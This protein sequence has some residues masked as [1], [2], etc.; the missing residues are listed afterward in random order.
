MLQRLL[1][2]SLLIVV[3]PMEAREATEEG[4]TRLIA[5]ALRG[6]HR[7]PAFVERDRYRHPAETLRFFGWQPP[8]TVVEIWPSAGWYTEILAPIT[9]PR[10]VY[11]AA[12]FAMTAD[13]TPE[14]RKGVHKEFMEKLEKRPKVYD[15]TV[16]TG[17]SVP[18]R[19]TIAPP[20]SAD[21]VLTF[22]NVHNWMKG[23]YA[24]TMFRI[25]ARALKPGG[26]LGVVE[27]RARPGTTLE[28]M[29]ESGYVT[30][31]HVIKLA[32]RAGF[33]LEEKSEI[34]AN[35]ADTRDHP[36]GVWTLPPSLRHCRPIDAGPERE[37]CLE[38][39]RAIGESDRMT[40]RFRKAGHPQEDGR[41]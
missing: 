2:F 3:M 35:P 18:E 41:G 6:D 21:M 34:N 38:K 28:E 27:H 25:M 40:L 13:R 36:A 14:W 17:L 19:T 4:R 1:I 9:R 23:D 8:M 39:Y 20:G 30:E 22:R 32:G 10:G 5:E 15:H 26:I 16:V 29:K 37:S 11:Y 33:V 12:G 24:Q 31:E 7:D